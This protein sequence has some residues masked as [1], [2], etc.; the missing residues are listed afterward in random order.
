MKMKAQKLLLSAF[1]MLVPIT[2]WAAMSV[3]QAREWVRTM[4]IQEE[5]ADA[6]MDALMEEG[7][8]LE[9]ATALAIDAAETLKFRI[10]L[11][12]AALC[13]AS[14][15][16]QF[17]EVGYIALRAAGGDEAE[18]EFIDN[19]AAFRPGFCG[20]VELKAPPGSLSTGDGGSQQSSPP[21]DVSPSS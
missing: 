13:L 21:E 3:G 12:E 19:I 10:A 18:R 9:D 6:I 15:E 8:S 4:E 2:L 1:L 17:G 7:L 14:G 16:E 11:A 5:S 20:S